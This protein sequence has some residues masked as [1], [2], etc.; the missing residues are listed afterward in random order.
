M[1]VPVHR[2]ILPIG[3]SPRRLGGIEVAR[4]NHHTNGLEGVGDDGPLRRSVDVGLATRD[5]DENAN[6]EHAEA[7][8]IGGP[9][10]LVLLHEG[11][12]HE[13]QGADVDTPVEDHIDALV[14]DGRVD[15]SALTALLSLD[16]HDSSL[17][18]VGNQ[19]RNV[20]FDPSCP[21]TDD[22]DGHNVAR[23]SGA[24]GMSLGQ[25]CGPKDSDAN[26]V[27]GTEE[28]NGTILS[29]VL[30]RNDGTKDRRYCKSSLVS[31]VTHFLSLHHFTLV[32]LVVSEGNGTYRSKTIGRRD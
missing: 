28:K 25:S 29:K 16:G 9:E 19:R 26:P 24:C 27:E 32:V 7:H 17:I 22:D 6:G 11:R 12:S 1:I 23:L 5:E 14:G 15:D 3:L 18:L 13:R 20:G 4:G 2:R 10:A 31:L 30:I 8:E 21:E